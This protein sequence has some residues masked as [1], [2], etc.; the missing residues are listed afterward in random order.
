MPSGEAVDSARG[1][2]RMSHRE[3]IR[4]PVHVVMIPVTNRTPVVYVNASSCCAC[5][6]TLPH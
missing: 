5:K 2:K 3:V 6:F 1:A 4:D